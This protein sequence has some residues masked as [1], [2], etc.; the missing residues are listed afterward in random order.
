LS[1]KRERKKMQENAQDSGREIE[2]VS[3]NAREIEKDGRKNKRDGGR[4]VEREV[5]YERE[6]KRTEK[7]PHTRECEQGRQRL[8][9]ERE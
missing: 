7:N 2:R 1:N 3:A 6:I 9:S 8:E 5:A 4:E